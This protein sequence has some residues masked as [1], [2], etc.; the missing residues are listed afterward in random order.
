MFPRWLSWLFLIALG[1]VIY[2]ASQVG[3][4]VQQPAAKPL[5]TPITHETYPALAD[6]TDT[7]RWKRKLDP[8][9]AS[10]MNCSLDAPAHYNGLKASI[11]EEAPGEGKGGACG[12]SITVKMIVWNAAGAKEYEGEFALALGSREL[13]SGLDYGLLGMKPG[14]V[15]KAVLPPYA[16]ER[17]KSKLPAAVLAALPADK[18][19]IVTVK[20]IK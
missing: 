15:R 14:A 6:L 19:A 18:L 17:N 8:N 2:S 13:A 11:I 7:E 9:Y 10:V 5:V 20:R 3:E 12:D 1:Y 4:Q 16:L